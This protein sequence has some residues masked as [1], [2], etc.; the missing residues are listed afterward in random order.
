MILCFDDHPDG[1][2]YLIQVYD[3]TIFNV[4]GY[5]PHLIVYDHVCIVED[6]TYYKYGDTD[7]STYAPY[8]ITLEMGDKINVNNL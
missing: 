1:K 5:V 7:L 8:A 6:E 2:A 3:R 4:I